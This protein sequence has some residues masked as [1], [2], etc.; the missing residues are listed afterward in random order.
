M[1]RSKLS[2]SK[3]DN[4]ITYNKL[5][6]LFLIG[7]VIGVLLEG[8][9]CLITKGH[10]ENHVV[11]VF[12]PLNI[13]YGSG[14]ILF[15]VGATKLSRQSL[16]NKVVIMTTIATLLE[17]FCGLFLKYKLGMKAWSYTNRVLNYQG[18]IC[19][20]F[21]LAWGIVAL[22][23]CKQLP[24]INKFLDKFDKRKYE[25]IYIVITCLLVVD[26]FLTGASIIRWSERHYGIEATNKFK[27]VIDLELSDKWM[28]N[29]F[30]E[31]RFIR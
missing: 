14:A 3:D 22:V 19:L 28:Q 26:L 8:F 5:L 15:Y 30:I 13:L 31:W 9:F 23:F 27:Q 25:I 21:S 20:E 7:C 11:S 18:I 12:F 10:W 2:V 17:L 4:N 6:V 29:R 16:S 1:D 24:N